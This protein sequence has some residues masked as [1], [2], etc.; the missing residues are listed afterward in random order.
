MTIKPE[1]AIHQLRKL[2]RDAH[3]CEPA[4]DQHAIDWAAK[5][6]RWAEYEIRFHNKSWYVCEATVREARR[7]HNRIQ[8]A[9]LP[10]QQEAQ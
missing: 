10:L 5:P 6:E 9:N 8:A 1:T 4:T 2:Y 3:H 7:L